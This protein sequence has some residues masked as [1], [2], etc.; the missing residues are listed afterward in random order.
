MENDE[1]TGKGESAIMQEVIFKEKSD[2]MEKL[3]LVISKKGIMPFCWIIAHLNNIACVLEF[4]K[5]I[6]AILHSI[7]EQFLSPCRKEKGL[8]QHFKGTKF[9]LKIKHKRTCP[10]A[11]LES[12]KRNSPF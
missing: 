2:L 11:I 6:N 12:I 10:E 5:N 3:D 4:R 7:E 9:F 1:E 8:L